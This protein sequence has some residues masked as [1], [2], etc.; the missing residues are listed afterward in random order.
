MPDKATHTP[1]PENQADAANVQKLRMRMIL[2][3]FFV[4]VVLMGLK[5]LTY[6]M[7]LSSAVLSDALES[8]INVV[9]SAFATISVWLAAKPPD[10]EHPYGHGKIEYFSA[11]FEGALIICAAAGIFYTGIKQLL[12]PHAL[13][14]LEEGV[15]I[16]LVATVVN[17]LLGVCLLR[18][19]R[20][21]ESITLEADGKHIITDVYTSGAVVIGLAMVH[22]TGWNRL[23]G[24]V[25]CL[26]G[27]NI[28]FTGSQLVRQSFARLMDASDPVLL[29]RITACLQSHRRPQWIDVHKLRAWRAGHLIHIDLH[30]VL[31]RDFSMEQAHDEAKDV[32][33][34]LLKHFEGHAGALVHIDPCSEALCP[35]CRQQSCRWRTHDLG[36]QPPWDR[37][38]LIRT[39]STDYTNL[40]KNP[41]PPS[42][43]LGNLDNPEADK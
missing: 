2:L 42:S 23:D 10:P 40:A 3:S 9:A 5:F 24:A 4:S 21:T 8:I 33:V 7:T 13:P 43:A 26:V 32:E 34:L 27:I 22:W 31:P 18:V 11:G 41:L 15:V 35:I 38:H 19:G 20:R 14:R 1:P 28:I 36:P 25:A 39:L 30:L 6:S 37:N 12:N 29:D 17:L 16:L